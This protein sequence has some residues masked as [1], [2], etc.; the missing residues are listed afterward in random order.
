MSLFSQHFGSI[1]KP[2]FKR[3]DFTFTS[4]LS[5][6]S[7][8]HCNNVLTSRRHFSY[9]SKAV[10]SWR[11]TMTLHLAHFFMIES[12]RILVLSLFIH[13]LSRI[14]HKAFDC[15]CNLPSTETCT[16]LIEWLLVLKCVVTGLPLLSL[17]YRRCSS[18]IFLRLPSRLT[19]IH[20]FV[21]LCARE[22]IYD[23]PLRA[24]RC[25]SSLCTT[26]LTICFAGLSW[27]RHVSLQFAMNQCICQ[28]SISSVGY[29][30][31]F[32]EYLLHPIWLMQDAHVL[33]QDLA[34]VW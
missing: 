25:R 7:F 9:F 5:S 2:F 16:L 18:I 34:H 12:W 28:V 17:M 15:P 10:T 6:T 32:F 13:S 3:T 8:H 31:F 24:H 20:H 29:H 19:N 23:V 1:C 11:Q 4:D 14:R 26:G 30:R 22:S 33:V 21:T 27:S